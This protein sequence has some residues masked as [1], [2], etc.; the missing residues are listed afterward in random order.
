[1]LEVRERL[2]IIGSIAFDTLVAAVWVAANAG[3]HWL[4]SKLHTAA[5]D[6]WTLVAFRWTFAITTLFVV[7]IFAV[8]DMVVIWR[9]VAKSLR[10][11][12]RPSRLTETVKEG[13]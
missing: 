1:M 7:I 6:Q 12:P 11:R 13:Q 8:R 4:E 10:E 5:V 2:S 3:V 9:K